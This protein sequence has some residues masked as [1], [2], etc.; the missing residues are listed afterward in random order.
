M[1]INFFISDNYVA[2]KTSDVIIICDL[3]EFLTSNFNELALTAGISNKEDIAFLESVAKVRLIPTAETACAVELFVRGDTP[4]CPPRRIVLGLLPLNFSRHNTP[5]RSH[6]VA[7]TI[8]AHKGSSKDLVVILAPK[9]NDYL[10]PQALSVSRQFSEYFLKK[11]SITESEEMKVSVVLH[12]IT[13]QVDGTF[14]LKKLTNLSKGIRQTQRL[15]DTPP[16]VLHTDAYVKE[17]VIVA[18]RLGC[19]IKV[20]IEI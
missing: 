12:A 10:F 20:S 9:N 6:S 7:S 1:D 2:S 5:S 17:C 8:K 3:K 15:V 19:A 16:N 18:N 4:A 14:L 13:A 11:P